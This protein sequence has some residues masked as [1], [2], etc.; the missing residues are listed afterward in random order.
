MRERLIDIGARLEVAIDFSEDDVGELDRA[1]LSADAAGVERALL[2]LAATHARGRI[3]REGLRVAIVGKPNVGKSSLLNLLL[4][5]ERAIVTPIPGTTRDTLEEALDL[6][7][8]PIVLVDTAGI[9]GDAA[10]VERLGI[11]RARSQIVAADLVIVMLDGSRPFAPEDR[12]VLDAT[13]HKSRILLINKA[14]LPQKLTFPGG[15]GFSVGLRTSLLDGRGIDSLKREILAAGASGPP[16]NEGI[17]VLRER[18]R[19]A[20]ELAARA[21]GRAAG[22]LDAGRSPDLV[23]VDVMNALDHLEGLVGAT[24]SEDVLERIFSEFCIGK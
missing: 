13:R 10:E 8:V 20:L 18:Q 22:S 3:L 5:T 7:G 15:A 4:Q 11:D 24:S 14:D 16:L 23:A 9:R 12:D 19:S 17:V 2:A 6:G 1:T 21:A